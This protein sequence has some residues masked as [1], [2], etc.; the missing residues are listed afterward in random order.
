MNQQPL[1]ILIHH[2]F[3]GFILS[4]AFSAA[5]VLPPLVPWF[6]MQCET[7]AWLEILPVC[8]KTE[9]GW[10]HS[11]VWWSP[12]RLLYASLHFLAVSQ[13]YCLII[14]YVMLIVVFAQY[15]AVKQ[16][17]TFKGKS[18]QEWVHEY[19][20][21]NIFGAQINACVDIWIPE[22]FFVTTALSILSKFVAIRLKG[23]KMLAMVSL[24]TGGLT[25]A[26]IISFAYFPANMVSVSH[27]LLRRRRAAASKYKIWTKTI[28]A[29]RP[30][31][32]R[33]GSFGILTKKSMV[34]LL[35]R[36]LDFTISLLSM[37]TAINAK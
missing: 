9:T 36:N 34:T 8:R 17:L 2:L 32:V 18:F 15:R 1:E 28:K 5:V 25:T 26:N 24:I 27:N 19:N 23:G 20:C 11:T 30:T 6:M 7:H 22:I 31:A 37:A 13:Y 35:Y 10:E 12:Y 14:N 4:N 29:C 3:V 21:I 33:V 16:F